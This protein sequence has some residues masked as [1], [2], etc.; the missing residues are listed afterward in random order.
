[1]LDFVTRAAQLLGFLTLSF[2]GAV[3]ILCVAYI[4]SGVL[5]RATRWR[6]AR[7]SIR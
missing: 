7:R 3:I 4:A 5:R 1:M 6:Y 2:S